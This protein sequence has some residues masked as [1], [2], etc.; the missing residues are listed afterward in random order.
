MLK[1]LDAH[2]RNAER[3][4]ETVPTGPVRTRSSR[5]PLGLYESTRVARRAC[6]SPP[7]FNSFSRG[8]TSGLEL[9]PTSN[10][11]QPQPQPKSQEQAPVSRDRERDRERDTRSV[12]SVTSTCAEAEESDEHLFQKPFAV[13]PAP[14]PLPAHCHALEIHPVDLAR[15]VTPAYTFSPAPSP[16]PPFPIA[17]D[18]ELHAL[19]S[20]HASPPQPPH[21]DADADA[22]ER[23]S[24][25]EEVVAFNANALPDVAAAIIPEHTARGAHVHSESENANCRALKG[26]NRGRRVRSPPKSRGKIAAPKKIQNSS[27]DAP[28]E[29]NEPEAPPPPKAKPEKRRRKRIRDEHLNEVTEPVSKPLPTTAILPEIHVSDPGTK[30]GKRKA[31]PSKSKS[32]WLDSEPAE[33]KQQPPIE[34]LF[35]ESEPSNAPPKRRRKRR[36]LT[37]QLSDFL[38]NESDTANQI[39]L[40][41][42]ASPPPQTRFPVSFKLSLLRNLSSVISQLASGHG[43]SH[44][45]NNHSSASNSDSLSASHARPCVVEQSAEEQTQPPDI[46]DVSAKTKRRR[47]RRREERAAEAEAA[48]AS[49]PVDEQDL[50]SGTF[51]AEE[52]PLEAPPPRDTRDHDPPPSSLQ[53]PSPAKAAKRESAPAE[54]SRFNATVGPL[55]SPASAFSPGAN[56]GRQGAC[57]CSAGAAGFGSPSQ[58]ASS[59]RAITSSSDS[60]SEAQAFRLHAKA[61]KHQADT[62]VRTHSY[63][64]ITYGVHTDMYMY[65][66]DKVIYSYS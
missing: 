43:V 6:P 16:A 48:A 38:L 51:E 55:S 44:P 65:I 22:D 53:S 33:E 31:S 62:M 47:R 7:A 2:S 66:R 3:E 42:P 49:A 59:P 40:Q 58:G 35:S 5:D 34:P 39:A 4:E 12:L 60:Q 63:A 29:F 21:S 57:E 13:A 45:N 15:Y 50:Y 10:A 23:R 26:T 61:L 28:A 52:P 18:D 17:R 27:L 19:T 36:Q 37:A 1:Q 56:A 32:K 14:A 8:P 64:Y 20:Q 41:T 9:A 30:P 24:T 46:P 25:S 54:A 11:T